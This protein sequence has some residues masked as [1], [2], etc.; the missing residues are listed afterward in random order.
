MRATHKALLL[1]AIATSCVNAAV[2]LSQSFDDVSSLGTAGWSIQNRSNPAGSTSWFQGN[3]SV[4]SSQSG[5]A[6]SYIAANFNAAG[7]GGNVSDWL[8]RLR[9]A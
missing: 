3:T 9:S 5:A 7:F 4:F 2:V 8:S 1:S 6:N